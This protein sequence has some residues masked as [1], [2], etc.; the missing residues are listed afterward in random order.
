M[1]MMN[2][3][4]VLSKSRQA[5]FTLVEIVAVTVIV[6]IL[7]AYAIPRMMGPGEFAVHTAADRL[8]AALHYAQTLAQRQGV[9]T[10][11]TISTAAPNITVS[12]GGTPVGF[13]NESYNGQYKVDWH[14]DVSVVPSAPAVMPVAITFGSDGIPS[15]TLPATLPVTFSINENGVKRFTVIVQPTGFVQLGS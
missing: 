5:G 11:V 8:V 3:R 4:I 2:S 15:A 13:Q 7:A 9:A 14:Y 10:S 1:V 12:Q 6:T